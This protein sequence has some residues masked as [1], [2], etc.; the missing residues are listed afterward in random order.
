MPVVEGTAY[1]ASVKVPNV[2]FEPM[3]TVNLVVADDV[4]EDFRSRGFH[5]KDMTEG[6]ALIIKR[7][8]NGRDGLIR[9]A[10]ELLD[11]QKRPIDVTVGNGSRVKVQY[12]VWSSEYKGKNFTGLDFCKMQVLDLVEYGGI[13]DEFD[14]YDDDEELDEL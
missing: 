2:N 4:A 12:R 6:P 14:M 11:R 7:K 10:P 8:V 3:Y 1:W 5:I 9:S 13:P